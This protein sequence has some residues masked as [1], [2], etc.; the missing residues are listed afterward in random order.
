MFKVNNKDSNTTMF[1]K[2][3]TTSNFFEKNLKEFYQ[4]FQLLKSRKS[5][6]FP[7]IILKIIKDCQISHLMLS[8]F[9][10]INYFLLPFNHQES[11]GKRLLFQ[12]E[13]LLINSL[14]LILPVSIPGEEKKLKKG[15][16]KTFWGTAKKCE[17]KHL[18]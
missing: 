3:S 5:R 4:L 1:F 15:L 10:W 2:N 16:H 6:L 9:E 14:K 11:M 17:N 8:E 13:Q 7:F 12:V 18:T